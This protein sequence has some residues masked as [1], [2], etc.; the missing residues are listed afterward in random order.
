MIY[1]AADI[2]STIRHFADDCLIYRRISSPEDHLIYT[3]GRFKQ[4]DSVGYYMADE[5][6]CGQM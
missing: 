4:T 3:T 5:L 6:Q 2:Q 1:V